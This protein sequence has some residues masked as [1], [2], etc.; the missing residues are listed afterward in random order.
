MA[1][2]LIWVLWDPNLQVVA[3]LLYCFILPMWLLMCAEQN[4]CTIGNILSYLSLLLLGTYF[5][6]GWF[7]YAETAFTENS[8]STEVE[9][10]AKVITVA[11]A[12]VIIFAI[13]SMILIHAGLFY[14]QIIGVQRLKEAVILFVLFLMTISVMSV[15]MIYTVYTRYSQFPVSLDQHEWIVADTGM[16]ILDHT[17][18]EEI[19]Q[20]ELDMSIC[21]RRSDRSA[22]TLTQLIDKYEEKHRQHWRLKMKLAKPLGSLYFLRGS[23]SYHHGR[24]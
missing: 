1:F 14:I 24:F 4:L 18:T 15:A 8:H 23:L 9:V 13:L 6:S 3:I 12:V 22:E 11:I 19:R 16:S 21:G 7:W 10:C 20:V 2:S 17:V 5:C